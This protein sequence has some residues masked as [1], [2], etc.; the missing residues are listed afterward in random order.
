M[1]FCYSKAILVTLDNGIH[2]SL[3]ILQ[4]FLFESHSNKNMSQDIQLDRLL[5]HKIEEGLYSIF[6][7]SSN[8]T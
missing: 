1:R 3:R 8:L 5:K 2:F 4:F 7:D 6:K